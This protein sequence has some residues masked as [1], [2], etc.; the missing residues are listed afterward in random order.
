MEWGGKED[1]LERQAIKGGKS[2]QET[3]ASRAIVE[4]WFFDVWIAYN[5]LHRVR[6]VGFSVSSIPYSEIESWLNIHDIYDI[7]ERRY[8]YEVVIRIDAEFLTWAR[9][10]EEQG[11]KKKPD[12]PTK[13]QQKRTI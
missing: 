12:P 7:D 5:E 11:R 13:G 8:Y 4:P 3:W 10:K 1:F 9:N 6:L 2:A